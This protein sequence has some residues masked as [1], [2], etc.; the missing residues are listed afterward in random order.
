MLAALLANADKTS[1]P[2]RLFVNDEDILTP[3]PGGSGGVPLESISWEFSGG[4]SP[5]TMAFEHW[6]P[7]RAFNIGGHA[8]VR[9]WSLADETQFTGN[10]IARVSRPAFGTGR[11]VEMRAVDLSLDLDRTVV[12]RCS[13]PAGLS[14]QAII[15]GLCG[16][17]L[18]GSDITYSDSDGS[19]TFIEAYNISMPAMTFEMQTLRSALE[20][21]AITANASEG[22]TLTLYVDE[23]G[24]LNYHSQLTGPAAPYVIV[25]G[26]PAGGQAN[27][28]DL[29]LTDDD[30]NIVNAVYVEG[31]NAAGSGWVTKGGSI[32]QYGWAAEVLSAPDSDTATKKHIIG[33]SYVTSRGAPIRRG[34]FKTVGKTGWLP[35][36]VVTI[37]SVELGLS[38]ATFDIKHVTV[39]A[40]TGTPTYEHT[41]E[42]GARRPSASRNSRFNPTDA[43]PLRGR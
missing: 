7:P 43:T 10:L 35:N 28:I 39:R 32:A 18:M 6:D 5:A 15:Q 11:I 1:A 21:V 14:D 27:A 24:R 37:T 13:F 42:F 26:V 20:Q 8:K 17:F 38:A 25:E 3:Q 29:E 4:G 31:K 40:L 22:V 9:F 16:Q 19:S 36:Q 41:I 34:S 12:E 30:S 33:S 23:V 2:F